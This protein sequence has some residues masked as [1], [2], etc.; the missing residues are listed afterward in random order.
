MAMINC[1]KCNES[2]S[3]KAKVC[4]YCDS[5]LKSGRKKIFIIIGIVIVILIVA[6]II[7]KVQYDKKKEKEAREKY[8]AEYNMCVD[9]FNSIWRMAD[10][11]LD[12]SDYLAQLTNN[13]WYG[14]IF[15]K[16]T[17]ENIKYI[18]KDQ[19]VQTYQQ[20][21]QNLY[22]DQS[23]KNDINSIKQI[24]SDIAQLY[25]DTENAPE[26]LKEVRSAA[27]DFMT[28][29]ND[30]MNF[31]TEVSGALAAYA[32]T[33]ASKKSAYDS[34]LSTYKSKIPDRLEK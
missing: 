22:A 18:Y 29:Y 5:K 28:A 7:L 1:P 16:A 23:I 30:R 19:V 8:V 31:S 13:V 26:E 24:Q 11:T 20:A 6:A 14:A 10:N 34:K 15:N 3:S 12:K 25:K 32:T 4:P 2:I 33:Y 21:L 9:K 27:N 17:T